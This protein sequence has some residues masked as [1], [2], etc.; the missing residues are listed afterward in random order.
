MH[1]KSRCRLL[2]KYVYYREYCREACLLGEKKYAIF[3]M[4]PNAEE[5][6]M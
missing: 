4:H 3:I 5:A 6:G 2:E 1:K